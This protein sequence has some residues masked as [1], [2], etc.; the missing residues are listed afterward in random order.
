MNSDIKRH[1][2]VRSNSW[3]VNLKAGA[4]ESPV[5]AHDTWLCLL[6]ASQ[7]LTFSSFFSRDT[8]DDEFGYDFSIPY[9]LPLAGSSLFTPKNHRF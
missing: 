3:M 5:A 9:G 2:S 6:S 4:E 7:V 1:G 8:F